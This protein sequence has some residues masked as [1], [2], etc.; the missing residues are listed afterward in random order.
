[1]TVQVPYSYKH[2]SIDMKNTCLLRVVAFLLLSWSSTSFH[3]HSLSRLRLEHRG[4]S[5]DQ[6]GF[7]QQSTAVRTTSVAVDN[8]TNDELPSALEAAARRKKILATTFNLVKAVAGSGILALPGG[9]ATMSDF[10]QR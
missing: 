10:K 3:K 2:K 4:G 6:Q 1:M 5:S 7:V 9:I 8:S